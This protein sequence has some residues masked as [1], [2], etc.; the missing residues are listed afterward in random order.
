MPEHGPLVAD[1]TLLAALPHEDLARLGRDGERID[2]ARNHRMEEPGR[3]IAH[4][5]F[6]LSGLGSVVAV[7]DRLR[8]RRIEAGIFGR[9]GM[10][11]TAVV[12]GNDRSPH[13]TFTQIA[14]P[15]LRVPA[16]AVRGAMEASE[17]LRRL[18]LLYAQVLLVQVAHTVLANGR[19][20]IEERLARWVLMAHDRVDGD[21]VPLTH[22]F[23]SL[24]LGVRRAGVTVATHLLEGQ[25][26]IRAT[27]GL[28]HVTDREGLEEMADGS[29]GVPEAEYRRLI[30]P[31][32]GGSP[33]PQDE[34]D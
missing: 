28:I 23:L 2:L 11:G 32:G 7:G 4:I 13:E 10:S 19:N 1:N 6:P 24:M 31:L 21:D 9:D 30:G 25:G 20:K 22:E 16:D 26:L 8:D 29:Y 5:Y 3:P 12:L 34:D 33:E 17:A 27:R 14:G 18:L 15:A